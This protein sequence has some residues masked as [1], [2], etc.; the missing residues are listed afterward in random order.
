MQDQPESL[1][2][3]LRVLPLPVLGFDH[4]TSQAEISD[5]NT[6]HNYIETRFLIAGKFI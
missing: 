6:A 5:H 4:T 2:Q 3:R 1:Q